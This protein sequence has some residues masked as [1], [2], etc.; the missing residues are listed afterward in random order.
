MQDCTIPDKTIQDHIKPKQIVQLRTRLS[1]VFIK[2]QSLCLGQLGPGA[3]VAAK[4]RSDAR[5]AE[6]D[7]RREA[8]AHWQAH[9][10]GRGLDRVGML[11][12][13]LQLVVGKLGQLNGKFH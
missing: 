5:R 2:T 1:S 4:R 8:Q 12:V 11:F 6:T 10:M 7:R 9:V 3:R 13:T